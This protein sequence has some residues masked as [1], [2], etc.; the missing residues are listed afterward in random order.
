MTTFAAVEVT[1]NGTLFGGATTACVP[2][3]GV[4]SVPASLSIGHANPP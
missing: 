4:Q 1:F 3:V 2:G